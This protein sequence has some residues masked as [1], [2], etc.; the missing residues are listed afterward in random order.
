MDRGRGLGTGGPGLPRGG[1]AHV[2]RRHRLPR[3]LREG[4][5]ELDALAVDGFGAIPR[6]ANWLSAMVELAEACLALGDRE[7]AA[8]VHDLIAPF[9]E[10]TGCSGRAACGSIRP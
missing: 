9:A 5:A 6:D 4:Q 8:V 10:R 7:H 3:H 1:G 2:A